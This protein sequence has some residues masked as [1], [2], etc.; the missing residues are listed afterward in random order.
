[1]RGTKSPLLCQPSASGLAEGC[2]PPL[3]GPVTQV[4]S[5]EAASAQGE[6]RACGGPSVQARWSLTP[7]GGAA[8]TSGQCPGPCSSLGSCPDLAFRC[9]LTRSCASSPVSGA[10]CEMSFT[11]TPHLPGPL[12]P[13]P[14]GATRPLRVS[15]PHCPRLCRTPGRRPEVFLHVR[16][17]LLSCVQLLATPWTEALQAPLFMGFSR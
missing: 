7:A 6:A 10:F 12:P 11:C 14:Q 5:G 2:R 17:C 8:H 9:C 15:S 16:A 1:M 13:H 3:A 4:G